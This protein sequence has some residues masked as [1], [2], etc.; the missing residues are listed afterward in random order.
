[1][2]YEIFHSGSWKQALLLAPCNNLQAHSLYSSGVFLFQRRGP[3]LYTCADQHSNEYLGETMQISGIHCTVLSFSVLP[4]ALS[5]SL[6]FPRHLLNS[7]RL[8]TSS[9]PPLCALQSRNFLKEINWAIL[10]ITSFVSYL[11]GIIGFGCPTS[12]ILT[13][14]LLSCFFSS[15]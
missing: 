6:V 10:R 15:F 2:N 11:S 4:P 9:Y 13:V 7:E 3:S 8:C 14:V 12:N 5:S 1:M